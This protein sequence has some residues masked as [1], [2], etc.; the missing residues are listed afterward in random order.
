M[1]TAAMPL[2]AHPVVPAQACAA[3]VNLKK[4]MLV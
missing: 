3:V 4:P 1:T 2:R